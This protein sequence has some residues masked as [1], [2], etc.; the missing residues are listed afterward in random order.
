LELLL[1]KWKRIQEKNRTKKGPVLL[2]KDLGMTSSVVRDLFSPDID[3]VVVDSRKL[4]GKIR[5]YVKQVAPSLIPKLELYKGKRPIFDHY[6]IEEEIEKSLSRKIW[7]KSGGYIIFDQTEAM[8]VIDVNSGRSVGEKDHE[9]NALKTDMEAAREIARQLRLRDVGGIVVIDFIDL[10]LEKNRKKVVLELKRELNKDRAA[11]DILPMNDF[12]LVNLT[13]ERVRPS[14]L[15]RYSEPCP[16]CQ[17]LGRIPAKST[18]V[19]KIERGIHQKKL[20]TH[21]RSWVLRVNPEI[22]QYLSDGLRSRI[23]HLMIKYFIRIKLVPDS[24]LHG[25]EF[26]LRTIEEEK[27]TSQQ[28]SS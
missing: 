9:K 19:S 26:L 24:S 5:R 6:Y 18:I 15:Y 25:E 27:S 21:I 8:F 22:A 23:R 3:C 13:R 10:T 1:K 4:L 28:V 12:G 2:Y 17:G 7:M 16:R 20:E 14:L 11:Y